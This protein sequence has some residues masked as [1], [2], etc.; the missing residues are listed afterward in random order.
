MAFFFGFDQ[1][2]SFQTADQGNDDSGKEMAV[3][4]VGTSLN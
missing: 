3:G 1:S 2:L 4:M